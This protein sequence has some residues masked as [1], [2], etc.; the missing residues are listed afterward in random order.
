MGKRCMSCGSIVEDRDKF[1]QNCGS[2][3]FEVK[4]VK[5]EVQEFKN[6]FKNNAVNPKDEF[7][8]SNGKTNGMAIASLVCSLVGLFVASIVMGIVSISLSRS[9]K[10]RIAAFKEGGQ[11]MATAGFVIGI[12]DLA[13]GVIGIFVRST[14][15]IY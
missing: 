15:T 9:A 7:N 5:N 8:M 6:E 1:C 4:E 2:S 3:N 13:L 14:L 11:G 12:I 10:A